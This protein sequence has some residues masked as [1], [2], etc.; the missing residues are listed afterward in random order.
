MWSLYYPTSTRLRDTFCVLCHIKN[1]TLAQCGTRP[2]IMVMFSPCSSEATSILT[3]AASASRADLRKPNVKKNREPFTSGLIKFPRSVQLAQLTLD[4]L[5]IEST[6]DGSWSVSE[7][8]KTSHIMQKTFFSLTWGG[9]STHLKRTLKKKSFYCSFA[10]I[11]YQG[12]M[13]YNRV[14]W[15]S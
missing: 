12:H 7:K 15:H 11:I 9:L 8:R 13:T 3:L 4:L 5:L 6:P 14:T 10:F 2:A 1:H